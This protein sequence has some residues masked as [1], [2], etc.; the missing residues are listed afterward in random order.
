MTEAPT[1]REWGDLV[2]EVAEIR[3]DLRT[4]RQLLVSQAE[5]IEELRRS[6]LRLR[7]RINTTISVCAIVASVV[8]FLITV[9]SSFVVKP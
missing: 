1:G 6:E 2:R 5:E 3:H 4:S 7:T 8:A 9:G